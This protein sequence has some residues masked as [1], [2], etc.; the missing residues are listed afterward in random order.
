[1]HNKRTAFSLVI[2]GVGLL[3]ISAIMLTLATPVQAQCGSQASSCKNCHEVQGEMP[4]NNDG[5]SWHEAHAFGDFCYICHGGNQQATDAESAHEGMVDPL[6]D[7][8]A[9]CQQCHVA[10]LEE[11]AQVYA[12]TLGVTYGMGS[13]ST[14]S[15]TG[16][17]T[18]DS[19]M[20]SEANLG[21]NEIV[22]DDPNLVDYNKIY[23]ET[24]LGVRSINWGNAIFALL[25]GALILGG[26]GFI[27][28][29]EGWVGVD[30]EKVDEY[31][32]DLVELLPEISH[33]TP[34][35]RKK[36]QQLLEDPKEA[37]ETLTRIDVPSAKEDES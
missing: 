30:Y 28:Y 8:Q 17:N 9:S 18:S 29:N 10:D 14:P 21:C 34:P 1:M 24:V 27:L 12:D 23:E 6:S 3:M 26:G 15:E 32:E 11:R 25:I 7:V 20:A 37:S 16:D 19:G 5:T 4:V 36:L 33:L 13:A 22:V 35:A 2:V 31:P